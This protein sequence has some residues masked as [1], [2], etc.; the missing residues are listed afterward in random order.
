MILSGVSRPVKIA[1]DV[2]HGLLHLHVCHICHL[3]L[4]SP[5]LLLR[6]EE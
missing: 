5:N 6:L 1:Q 2:A 3:D 4:K